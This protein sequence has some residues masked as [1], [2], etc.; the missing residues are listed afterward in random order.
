MQSPSSE[1]AGRCSASRS[2]SSSTPRP[3]AMWPLVAPN[4]QRAVASPSRS[5]RPPVGRLLGSEQVEDRR[6]VAS[7]RLDVG[8]LGQPE[9]PL[10]M[11]PPRLGE[12]AGALE[13]LEP[14]LAD[15]LQHPEAR[16]AVRG[17]TLPGEGLSPPP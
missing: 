4:S 12:L 8:P 13:Q 3:S 2:A 11:P 10:G 6:L 16:L 14:E 9:V 5:S 17:G 15:R 7:A 1:R